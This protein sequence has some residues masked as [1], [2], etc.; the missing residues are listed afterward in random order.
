[1]IFIHFW[2]WE[3]TKHLEE[4]HA[5]SVRSCKLHK[6]KKITTSASICTLQFS[7]EARVLNTEPPSSSCAVNGDKGPQSTFKCSDAV[8]FSSAFIFK[9]FPLVSD[10]WCWCVSALNFFRYHLSVRHHSSSPV[11]AVSSNIT[12][13]TSCLSPDTWAVLHIAQF[14]CLFSYHCSCT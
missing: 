4:S 8:L 10:S 7:C 5:S 13:N 1:M 12:Y 9:F 14:S 6:R 11:A 3:K 2:W